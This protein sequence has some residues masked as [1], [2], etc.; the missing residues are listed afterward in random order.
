MNLLIVSLILHQ[1][2]IFQENM[3][4]QLKELEE[5]GCS[6]STECQKE[7]KKE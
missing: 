7:E 3:F 1:F 2:I 6:R 5:C 4:K